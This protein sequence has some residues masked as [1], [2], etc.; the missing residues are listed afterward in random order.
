MTDDEALSLAAAVV[1][2][3]TVHSLADWEELRREIHKIADGAPHPRAVL[4]NVSQS[5]IWRKPSA[6]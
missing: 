2:D 1:R 6:A 3:R 5:L 4:A